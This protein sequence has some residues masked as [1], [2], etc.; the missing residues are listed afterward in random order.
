MTRYLEEDGSGFETKAG[1]LVL[2]LVCFLNGQLSGV[3]GNRVGLLL[4]GVTVLHELFWNVWILLF[5]TVVVFLVVLFSLLRQ[6]RVVGV[7]DEL[8]V[9]TLVL[10]IVIGLTGVI[11]HQH[12]WFCWTLRGKFKDAS[13]LVP[14]V[15]GY[16]STHNLL[17]F[18]KNFVGFRRFLGYVLHG[19][20]VFLIVTLMSPYHDVNGMHGNIVMTLAVVAGI[21]MFVMGPLRAFLYAVFLFGFIAF[22]RWVSS[23]SNPASLTEFPGGARITAVFFF[24]YALYSLT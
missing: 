21:Y 1:R 14:F 10:G 22:M 19:I 8:N 18:R 24:V 15:F 17:W 20:V 3:L 6:R 16:L 4:L 13:A 12:T 7:G 2:L 11:W 23:R 9:K 5:L